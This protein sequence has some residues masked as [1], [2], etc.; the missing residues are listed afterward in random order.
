MP[1]KVTFDDGSSLSNTAPIRGVLRINNNIG[2]PG[3]NPFY[4]EWTWMYFM[5]NAM[6]LVLQT[7]PEVEFSGDAESKANTVRAWAYWWKGYLYSH[8]GSIYYAGI[9][10]DAVNSTNNLYVSNAELINESNKNFDLAASALSAVSSTSDYEE[11]LSQLIPNFCQV[12]HG[13]VLSTDMWV[14]NINTMKARNLLVNKRVKDMS[15]GDWSSLL[16][17]VS[18]GVQEGDFVFTGRAP[19]TNFFFSANSGSVAALAVGPSNTHS[20]NERLIQEYK[21]GD[22]RFANNFR[23]RDIPF[24]DQGGTLIYGTRY[25][26]IDGGNGMPGVFTIATLAPDEYELY[27]AASYEENELMKAEAKIYLDQ[28]DDGLESIDNVRNYQGAG[29][30]NVSGSGLTSD[31]AKEELRR[32]RRVALI[33]RGISFYDARRWGVIDDV[34]KGGGRKNAVVMDLDGNI[35]TNCTINYNFLDYWDVPDDELSLNPPGEGSA[36][37]VNPN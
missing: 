4:Y 18:N 10:N 12:G 3:Q 16:T 15:S 14:R 36:E 2:S 37:V 9:I 24:V 1:D 20:I 6:N 21:E 34:S 8:L 28:I 13:G 27:I 17:L 26:L 11:V 32:E 7:L 22:M 35:K 19:E 30:D 23:E 33:F 31:E 5:N 29:I 25:E